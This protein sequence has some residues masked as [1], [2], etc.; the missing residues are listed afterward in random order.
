MIDL[1]DIDRALLRQLAA[2]GRTLLEAELAYQK[3]ADKRAKRMER[4]IS[5]RLDEGGYASWI[6]FMAAAGTSDKFWP[7]LESLVTNLHRDYPHKVLAVSTLL[8]P[9]RQRALEAMNDRMSHDPHLSASLHEVLSALSSVRSTAAI[10]AETEDIEPEWRA[11]FH[12]NLHQDS[13]RLALGAEALVSYLDTA[14]QAD[15]QGIAS[16]Q[17]EVEAWLAAA[18]VGAPAVCS[19]SRPPGCRARSSSPAC[20]SSFIPTTPTPTA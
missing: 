4:T 6:G 9:E 15:E 20:A 7:V 14:G 16:P 1:D 18:S 12:R 2:D 5:D 3:A 10:L 8:K 17:E 19:A 11:R 13:E